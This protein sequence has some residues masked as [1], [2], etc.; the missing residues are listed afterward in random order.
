MALERTRAHSVVCGQMRG[1]QRMLPPQASYLLGL[2]KPEGMV[3]PS[4]GFLGA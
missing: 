1:F 2:R 3:A 4:L